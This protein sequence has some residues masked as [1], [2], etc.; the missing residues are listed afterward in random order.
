MNIVPLLLRPRLL[1]IKNRWLHSG[2]RGLKELAT[3]LVSALMMVG[4]YISTLASLRDVT[5]L[6][7]TTTIDP[8]IPLGVML[9]TLFLMILLSASVSAI[10]A[11]FL[12]KDLDITLSAPLSPTEFLAG[13]SIDVGISV[14]W[15]VC[16][17]TI[18][19]LLA[20]GSFYN[21]DIIF[22][23]GAPLL[24]ILFFALAV[25]LGMITAI[26]FAALLPSE[27]GRPLLI[28]LFLLSLG[29][30]LGLM[31]GF[32]QGAP[33]SEADPLTMLRRATALG[34]NPWLPSTHCARALTGLLQRDYLVPLLT[35]LEC[36]GT[37][38]ILGLCMRLAHARLYERAL[39]RTGRASGILKIHSRSAQ[40]IAR[41]LFPFSSSVTRAIMTKEYKLFSRDL[42]HTVQ[43]GL[44]LGI[45]FV[46][47]YNYQLLQGP[48][49]MSEEALAVWKIF[50]LLSNIALG[51]L[52]VTSICSRFVFPSVSLE[53]ASFW[54]IQAS[55]ISL[56]DLLK[57][58]FKSWLLPV[59]CI[60]GVIF[61]SGAM[62]LNAEVPLV[63]ASCAA[64]VIICHG[65]VGLGVGFGALFSQ[66]EWEHST[67]LS[68]SLGNFV[69]ML[70]CMMFLAFNMVPLGIMFGTYMLF[71]EAVSSDQLV[72]AVLGG[73]LVSTYILN[74]LAVWWALSA[75]AKALQPK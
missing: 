28:A 72:A 36:V 23:I 18:P 74:K 33:L 15:M 3:L 31:N 2:R 34:S 27:K 73:G 63:V 53:G 8:A 41:L 62:A 48:S 67:Q 54:L 50:L 30:F 16:V 64:G 10:G 4:I 59:S 51:A 1:A 35:L 65:L 9:G 47:L 17:F 69:F 70:V 68:T 11:L 14:S 5:R 12:S 57:A 75:G 19:A 39:S 29:V 32:S 43:L 6:S 20:F 55:P 71:P 21:A 44:L 42:T 49:K 22:M 24:C 52:V 26:L 38:S 61:V 7:P 40:R 46:Y 66:F 13:K 37:L 45:T 56:K 60:G 25:S 58:K